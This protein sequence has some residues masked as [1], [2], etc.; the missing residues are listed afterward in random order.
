MENEREREKK[1]SSK[2]EG[3]Q[4]SGGRKRMRKCETAEQNAKTNLSLDESA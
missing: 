4:D 1:E 2:R 3:K